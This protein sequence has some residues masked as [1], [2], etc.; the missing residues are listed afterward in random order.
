MEP[1][2]ITI[3]G[4]KRPRSLCDAKLLSVTQRGLH[5]HHQHVHYPN[6]NG[7][8]AAGSNKSGQPL[9]AVDM[10]K[11][12]G[13]WPNVSFTGDR[14]HHPSP[15]RGFVMNH[16]K[17]PSMAALMNTTVPLSPQKLVVR[18]GGRHTPTRNSLRHSRMICLSQQQGRGLHQ[19][20]RLLLLLPRISSL[21]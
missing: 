15:G 19:L 7:Q 17:A 11:Y 8:L 18:T 14:H 9:F 6:N 1:G 13:S 2:E 10:S 4:I 5:H 20:I 16:E 12:R 3:S 21:F